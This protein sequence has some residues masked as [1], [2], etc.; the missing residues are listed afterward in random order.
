MADLQGGSLSSFERVYKLA[1]RCA[2]IDL[3]AS[4]AIGG[5]SS[6]FEGITE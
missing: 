1:E 6:T 5:Q 3:L 4:A 2:R